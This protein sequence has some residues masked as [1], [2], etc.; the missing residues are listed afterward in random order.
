M[1]WFLHIGKFVSDKLYEYI[2]IFLLTLLDRK[3]FLYLI[4]AMYFLMILYHFF[5]SYDSFWHE[6][7][8]IYAVFFWNIWNICHSDTFQYYD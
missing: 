5:S 6:A 8:R 2:S 3:G 1:I 7:T 4:F